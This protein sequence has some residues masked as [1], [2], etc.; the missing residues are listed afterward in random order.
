MA[1]ARNLVLALS[2]FVVG[3]WAS[4]TAVGAGLSDAPAVRLCGRRLADL[5]WMI[6]MDRGGVH[7]HMDRRA[8]VLVDLS[9]LTS[10]AMCAAG[11]NLAKVQA[12]DLRD[13]ENIL[14]SI[15]GL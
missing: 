12:V 5:V 6:C 8:R 11:R 7:S 4:V 1:L 10:N 3:P 13:H 15:E 2:L 14:E 9:Y